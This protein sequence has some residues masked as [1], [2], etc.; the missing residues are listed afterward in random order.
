MVWTRLERAE[1]PFRLFAC[2]APWIAG[3]RHARTVCTLARNRHDVC[4]HCQRMIL[5]I[6]LA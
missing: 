5:Y 1:P 3:M 2:G 6:Q 4:R